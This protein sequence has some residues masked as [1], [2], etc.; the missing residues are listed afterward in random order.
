[1]RKTDIFKNRSF[2]LPNEFKELLSLTGDLKEMVG[3]YKK[4]VNTNIIDVPELNIN[5]TK[6]DGE[7]VTKFAED[8][9]KNQKDLIS[10]A[11]LEFIDKYKR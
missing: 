9:N 8:R 1:M 5:N 7:V 6:L 2:Q 4:Q 10:L 11:I 3:W